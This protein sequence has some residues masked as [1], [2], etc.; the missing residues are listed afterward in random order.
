MGK[1]ENSFIGAH[2][3][4]IALVF[5][6]SFHHNLHCLQKRRQSL[7]EQYQ[8]TCNCSACIRNFPLFEQLPE[9]DE[10]FDDFISN[11]LDNLEN[12]NHHEARQAIDKYST[13]INNNIVFFP[14]YEISLL[15]E[16]ILRCFRVLEKYCTRSN[17]KFIES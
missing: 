16:C 11:D 7:M 3:T 12:F 17:I 5:Y 6:C 13:Y 9:H 15:Q 10:A 14:C 1:K 8:F 2:E 4:Y